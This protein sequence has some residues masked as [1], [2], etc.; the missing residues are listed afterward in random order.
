MENKVSYEEATKELN[1]I[2]DQLESGDLP[3]TKAIELFER[4]QELIKTCYL[5][6][7]IAKGKLSEVKENLGKL[8]EN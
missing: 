5:N 1:K 3:M 6:L 8:E 7:D 4:G 2:I